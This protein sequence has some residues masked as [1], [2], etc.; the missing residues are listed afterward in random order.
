MTGACGGDRGGIR[1]WGDTVS[2]REWVVVRQS[3]THPRVAVYL[4]SGASC[5][6]S[7]RRDNH[8]LLRR[9]ARQAV[10]DLETVDVMLIPS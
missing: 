4:P 8:L 9:W 3:T 10:G 2:V 1:C 5:Y 7:R 6:R